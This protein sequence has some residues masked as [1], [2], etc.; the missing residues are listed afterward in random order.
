RHGE[1]SPSANAG[2]LRD[3][4]PAADERPWRAAAP[5]PAGQAWLQVEQARLLAARHQRPASG[6][7]L[8]GGPGV[9]LVRRH[10]M[11]T[12][13][14]R[15]G[16]P[17]TVVAVERGDSEELAAREH[18]WLVRMAHWLSAVSVTV[19]TLS[20]LQIFMAFPSFGDKIPESDL[21]YVPEFLRI[22]GWLGGAFQWHFTFAQPFTL[23][24]VAYV[25]YLPLSRHWRRLVPRPRVVAGGLPTAPLQ[26]LL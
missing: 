23:A 26:F 6:A 4:R 7:R 9:L 13:S 3:V 15:S 5:A 17:V 18:P 22:G 12:M 25:A 24:C 16:L 10:L 14:T 8:L 1:L 2:V 20:G 21:L 19:M 11:G